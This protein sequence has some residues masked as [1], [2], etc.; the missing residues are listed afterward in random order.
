[1]RLRLHVTCSGVDEREVEVDMDP[2]RVDNLQLT[3]AI[4]HLFR[5]LT[6]SFKMLADHDLGLVFFPI[7]FLVCGGAGA[8][9]AAL[10]ATIAS[11]T[12]QDTRL[13][14]ANQRTCST[15]FPEHCTEGRR[16]HRW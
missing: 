16:G 13:A 6:L 11:G 9:A 12:K 5:P 4:T 15:L 14:H 7:V 1:M 10:P 8:F 2:L 3:C